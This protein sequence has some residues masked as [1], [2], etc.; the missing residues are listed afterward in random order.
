MIHR[1]LAIVQGCVN[2]IKGIQAHQ[3]VTH[4]AI[5][6]IYLLVAKETIEPGDIVVYSLESEAIPIVHRAITVQKLYLLLV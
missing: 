5:I 6:Y 1:L 4:T 3:R 2:E